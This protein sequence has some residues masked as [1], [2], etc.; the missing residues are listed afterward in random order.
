[1]NYH[2]M[3]NWTNDLPPNCNAKNKFYFALN[4][5]KNNREDNQI[6]IL[7]IGTYVGTSLIAMLD[8]L[9][10]ST[11]VAID[12]WK[13]SVNEVKDRIDDIR[14]G[15]LENTINYRD[16]INL[17]EGDSN[18]ILLKFVEKN[19]KFDFIYVD[20]SH[21]LLDTHYDTLLAFQCLK[22]NGVLAIDDYLWNLNTNNHLEIPYLGLTHFLEKYKNNYN[23]IDIDYRIF[24]QKK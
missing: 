20:G 23:I 17:I 7:E 1:M 13:I 2:G 9:P 14:K 19:E 15:F 8:F 5:V 12:N 3:Y 24:I 11:A 10:N 22:K 18:E 4:I 16:R 21:K 6:K